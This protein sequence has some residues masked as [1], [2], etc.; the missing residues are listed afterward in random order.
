MRP[1]TMMQAQWKAQTQSGESLTFE[2]CKGGHFSGLDAFGLRVIGKTG[3]ETL[4]G[5]NLWPVASITRYRAHSYGYRYALPAANVELVKNALKPGET[6][7]YSSYA[8]SPSYTLNMG[9]LEFYAADNRFLFGWYRNGKSTSAES[10]VIPDSIGETTAIYVEGYDSSWPTLTQMMIRHA[11]TS[12][13]YEAYN[14]GVSVPNPDTPKPIQCVKAGTMIS[15]GECQLTT[16]CDLFEGDIYYPVSGKVERHNGYI[17]SYNGETVP[18]GY[19]STTGELT[20]GATVV[21]PLTVPVVEQYAPTPVWS[22]QGTVSV[23]QTPVEETASLAA[24]MYV[25]R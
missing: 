24:T 9:Y 15:C 11:S 4:S 17:A 7:V 5:K 2:H 8:T 20:T 13:E 14:G 1:I 3:Q 25:R 18:D 21:Y 22:P 10:M 6:Y 23:T 16:P 12:E 19:T